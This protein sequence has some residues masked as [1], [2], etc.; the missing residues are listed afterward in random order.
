MNETQSFEILRQSVAHP[1]VDAMERLV[2][3]APDRKLNRVNALA[4]A[5][6]EGLDPEEVIARFVEAGLR[7][8]LLRREIQDALGEAEE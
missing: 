3:H 2:R 6:A 8:A 1:V 5:R 7:E 4:F